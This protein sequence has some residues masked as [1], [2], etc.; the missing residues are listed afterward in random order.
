MP[1]GSVMIDL[2]G[3]TLSPAEHTLLAHPRVGGVILFSRNYQDI[4]QLN[5]LITDVRTAAQQ[6]LLVAVDHEGGRVWRFNEGFTKLLP[7]KHH[8]DVYQ[9]DP[10]EGL[11]SAYNAGCTMATELLD[12]GID[13]SL[14]PVLDVEKGISE[15]I[16]DRAFGCDPQAVSKLAKAFIEG[17]NASGMCATGKHFPG[18]GGCALDSHIAQP[19]D[20][21]T[22]E[23]LLADDLIPFANLNNILGAIMPAHITYPAVDTVPTGFS[24]RWLQDILREQLGF[25]G[26]IISDCLSMKG[27]G[28]STAM[29]ADFVVRAQLAIDAG[30]DMVILCQQTRDLI[31]WFLDNLG[32]ESSVESRQ[33]LSNMA[34]QFQN[35]V[36]KGKRTVLAHAAL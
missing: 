30:C 7:A 29:A 25:K 8:G 24:R 31:S 12:C 26:A 1:Y 27:A 4:A 14:A 17:M 22:L 15:I 36:R 33:R 13:L 16:G 19:V 18:H 5:A 34:G 35:E 21:R 2:E 23:A 20:N 9:Q 3:K 6:P 32:R 10:A 11:K 28:A